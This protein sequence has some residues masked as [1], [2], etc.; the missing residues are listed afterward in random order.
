MFIFMRPLSKFLKVRDL[1]LGDT[2]YRGDEENEMGD[3]LAAIEL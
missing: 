2:S 1:G 3:N